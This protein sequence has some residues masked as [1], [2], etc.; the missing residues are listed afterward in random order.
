MITGNYAHNQVK[1]MRK[2]Y[3][4]QMLNQATRR[5]T[6]TLKASCT[7]CLPWNQVLQEKSRIKFLLFLV[8]YKLSIISR[9]STIFQ[10][11]CL[12]LNLNFFLNTTKP[13]DLADFYGNK[14]NIF[15]ILDIFPH[16]ENFWNLKGNAVER[17][18]PQSTAITLLNYHEV[19]FNRPAQARH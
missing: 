12:F 17:L 1:T 19:T 2:N 3:V 9:W 6:P 8:I 7:I 11:W 18:S 10:S 14:H 15:R 16:T 5:K 4:N 13:C